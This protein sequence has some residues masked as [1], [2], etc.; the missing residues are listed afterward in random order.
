MKLYLFWSDL[1]IGVFGMTQNAEGQ[2]L[3]AEFA[4]WSK[5]GQGEAIFCGSAD[6]PVAGGFVNPILRAIDRDGAYLGRFD[7]SGFFRLTPAGAR[8]SRPH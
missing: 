6:E 7:A 3:P 2:N 1:D 8:N 4:P 5:S